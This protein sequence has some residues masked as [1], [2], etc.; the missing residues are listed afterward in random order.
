MTEA[1]KLSDGFNEMKDPIKEKVKTELNNL[2]SKIKDSLSEKSTTNEILSQLQNKELDELKNS[3]LR[4]TAI[5]MKLKELN[6]NVWTIDGIYGNQ[7]WQA[8]KQFQK[9]NNV[10]GSKKRNGEFDGIAGGKTMNKMLED[11]LQKW[12]E[13][14]KKSHDKTNEKNTPHGKNDK[15]KEKPEFITIGTKKYQVIRPQTIEEIPLKWNKLLK[16]IYIYGGYQFFDNGR[17]MYL[18]DKSM[19]NSTDIIRQIKNQNEYITNKKNN[20]IKNFE[21]KSYNGS[22]FFYKREGYTGLYLINK[23]QLSYLGNDHGFKLFLWGKEDN[24][25]DNINEDIWSGY[26]REVLKKFFWLEKDSKHAN[27]FSRKW[28]KGSYAFDK[29]GNLYYSGTDHGNL[30]LKNLAKGDR[31]NNREETKIP[32][33]INYIEV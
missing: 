10:G 12:K 7:T 24:R 31:N 11:N 27:R 14:L 2:N 23:N 17:A 6:Y 16:K 25:Q 30:V 22:N 33:E 28:Y 1:L 29:E 9:N 19:H 8:V 21:L 20:L 13:S 32:E 4:N 26:K 5:Q 15:Q 18:K 3:L